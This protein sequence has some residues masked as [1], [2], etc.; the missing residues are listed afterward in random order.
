MLDQ[1]L[2][3]L[4]EGKAPVEEGHDAIQVEA[5]AFEPLHDVLEL[6]EG[7]LER[8]RV[9]SSGIMLGKRRGCGRLH[10]LFG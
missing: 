10:R 4:G 6:G 3:G 1:A 7:G 5:A 9:T 8:W 2:A